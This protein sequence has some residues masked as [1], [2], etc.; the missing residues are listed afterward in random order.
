MAR[1]RAAYANEKHTQFWTSK[2]IVGQEK[3][4]WQVASLQPRTCEIVERTQNQKS[5][6]L[7]LLLATSS[8]TFSSC[9]TL[10]T[11]KFFKK[12]VSVITVIL[13]GSFIMSVRKEAQSR[14]SAQAAG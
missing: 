1:G 12:I 4:A 8:S 2:K 14:G 6:E 11:I 3:Y 10:H 13:C 7:N 5:A 9:K